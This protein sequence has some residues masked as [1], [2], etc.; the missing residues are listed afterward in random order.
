M[1]DELE[2]AYTLDQKEPPDPTRGG[3]EPYVWE[4]YFL[5]AFFVKYGTISMAAQEAGVSE[6]AVTDRVKASPEFK[7]ALAFCE[8]R[9][10]DTIRH[11]VIRRAI[12][13]T[14]KPIYNRGK[15]IGVVY[16]YDN[17]HLQ[18]VAERML[19]NEFHL[20]SRI[21]FQGGADGEVNFKLELGSGDQK[22]D[23][24]A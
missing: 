8:E 14:E 22:E 6:Q 19:P 16:E 4:R 5:N 11:E 13:P 3:Y 24:S 12:E 9:L 20:P 18:W 2:R 17:R 21:E 1:D 15:L 10:R 23:D 7:K